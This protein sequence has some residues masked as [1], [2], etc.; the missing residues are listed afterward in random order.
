MSYKFS[1]SFVRTVEHQEYGGFDTSDVLRDG[2]FLFNDFE[3]IA[4]RFVGHILAAA[5][6]DRLGRGVRVYN[7]FELF[8]LLRSRFRVFE[9]DEGAESF[10]DSLMD[11]THFL[12]PTAPVKSV[13]LYFS[14]ERVHSEQ[15]VVE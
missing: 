15:S 12:V 14:F 2:W 13:E 6:E 3:E 8:G 9:S 11:Q 1:F 7:F 10:V 4:F 5:S